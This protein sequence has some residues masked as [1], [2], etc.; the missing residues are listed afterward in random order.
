MRASR[1]LGPGLEASRA[2]SSSVTVLASARR[3]L[4]AHMPALRRARGPSVDEPLLLRASM[5]APVA[6]PPI[7]A[8]LGRLAL[9]PPAAVAAWLG[10]LEPAPPASPAPPA[11]AASSAS[12]GANSSSSAPEPPAPLLRQRFRVRRERYAPPRQLA[13]QA[14]QLMGLVFTLL[15]PPAFSPGVPGVRHPQTEGERPPA[16]LRLLL[17]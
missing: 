14:G 17:P 13:P 6:A 2:R 1:P 10:A 7:A 12:A 15:G 8:R 5:R 11:P 16:V 4:R 3:A 9:G